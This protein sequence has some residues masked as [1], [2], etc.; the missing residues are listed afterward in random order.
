MK[1]EHRILAPKQG[2]IAKV[3]YSEGDRVDMGSPL[4]EIGD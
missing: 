1:M 4:V 3:H 2:E